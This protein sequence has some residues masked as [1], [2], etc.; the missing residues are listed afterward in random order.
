MVGMRRVVLWPQTV[1]VVPAACRQHRLQPGLRRGSLPAVQ[2]RDAVAVR[3]TKS[4][5]IQRLRR[6]MFTAA[7]VR[8]V[9]NI[10]A[11]KAAEV[12]DTREVAARI[13]FCQRPG[14]L[15]DKEG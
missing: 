2:H 13:A 4:G 10:A 12:I 8:A 6:G 14:L 3:Q 15:A 1:P 7:R 9:V 11:G 5:N